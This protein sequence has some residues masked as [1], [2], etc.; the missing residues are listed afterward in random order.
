MLPDHHSRLLTGFVDGQLSPREQKQ[1]QELL[2]GSA[3]ARAL[4]HNLQADAQLLSSM[5]RI[6]LPEE[7]A[8]GLQTT[9]PQRSPRIA[10]ILEKPARHFSWRT[11][12]SYAAAACLLLALA[13]AY[14]HRNGNL[15]APDISQPETP[16]VV[17]I[18][19]EMKPE[20][21]AV[22]APTL[23]AETK[24]VVSAP[25]RFDKRPEVLSMPKAD[26]DM[27]NAAPVANI[28]RLRDVDLDV[29][30]LVAMRDLELEKRRQEITEE[31][32][33]AQ[34][35]R[36]EIRCQESEVATNRLKRSLQNQ[37]IRLLIEPDASDRQRLRLPRT[38]Y[39][40][41]L[42]NVTAQECLAMLSGLR[43]VDRDEFSRSRS[44]NQ[45]IDLRIVRMSSEDGNR[46]ETLFGIVPVKPEWTGRTKTVPPEVT[47][48][49]PDVLPMARAKAIWRDQNPIEGQGSTRSALLVADSATRIRKNS[50]EG[51]LFLNTRQS[52]KAELLRLLIVLNPRK[53]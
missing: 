33:Q 47:S 31:L 9:L 53:G 29:P 49:D 43:Q 32:L 27:I 34:S 48:L 3:E 20:N 5:P 11:A 45:F 38:T 52:L 30:L 35:W 40:I 2:R 17:Q 41:L 42:D 36:L 6:R 12:G 50:N 26:V 23:L 39:A 1:A 46:L 15:V 10:K 24:R 14:M 44:A 22:K 28:P 37:G 18:D 7:F 25:N 51:Q 16:D 19:V 21:V 4:L 8:E 13:I